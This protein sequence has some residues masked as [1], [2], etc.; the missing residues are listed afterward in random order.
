MADYKYLQ[1][2]QHY[3]DRYDL[4]TIKRCLE[5]IDFWRKAYKEKSNDEKIK[6][7][8]PEDKLKGFSQF[9]NFELYATR[10][11]EYKR[12]NETID[13]WMESD[14]IKQD[15]YDHSYPPS[16]IV[17]SECDAV[18]HSTMK[19]LEDYM[20]EPL[21]V[22]FFFECPS[23]KK[24]KGIYENGEERVYKPELCPKCKKEVE[25][26]HTKKGKVITWITTCSCGFAETKVDDFEKDHAKWEKEKQEDTELL[27]KYRDEFCFSDKAGQEY[28][29]FTEAMDVAT[30]VREE[31][32]RKYDNSLYEKTIRTKKLS[33]VELEKLLFETLE[34]EKY[35]KLSFDKPEIGQFVVVPFT[36]QDAD[37][38]RKDHI[39]ASNLQK[40]IKSALEGTNWRLMSE[41]THYRLGYVSGR[42]KGFEREEDLMEIQGMKQ[43]KEASKI[44][45][46]KRMKYESNPLVQLAKMA[47]K[48]EAIENLRKKR[49]IH[50]PDGFT[51]EES[52]GKY[53][54]RVCNKYVSGEDAWWD[55]NGI[56]C[57]DC[58]RN[59]KEG[60]VPAEICT[61][62]DSWI[63]EW[64][65]KSDFS[66][67]AG[68]VKKLKREGILHGRDLKTEGGIIYYTVY[69]IA[70]NKEFLEKYPRKP[71][72]KMTMV[73][74]KG[75]EIKL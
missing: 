66:I 55:L 49:L 11:E 7:L 35:I 31:E 20:N 72:I 42:L 52:E 26:K 34:K 9:L 64:Q 13:K 50:E 46:E 44:D 14:R 22:L 69:L 29:E 54:C 30:E 23:C 75:H 36:V 10:G 2:K 56:K 47:G 41:G 1:D 40:L 70:E 15:K 73:D 48:H 39:S 21:R 51:L 33:I 71:K 53:N 18:I 25:T 38:S 6:N 17:C 68:T 3:I 45:S 5:V 62:D 27:E 58:Q 16:N 67:H 28:I 60:V 59:I 43:K 32:K 63:K 61:D 37:T 19:H 8:S 4:F 12:K 65:M 24:R 74:S 57:I